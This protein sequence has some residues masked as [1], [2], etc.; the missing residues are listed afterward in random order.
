MLDT[1]GARLGAAALLVNAVTTILVFVRLRR[2]PDVFEDPFPD[3]ET[4]ARKA[5]FRG[6]VLV[7]LLWAL[8]V[9]FDADLATVGLGGGAFEPIDAGVG[10]VLGLLVVLGSVVSG[11]VVDRL[12]WDADSTSWA[13]LW[14]DSPREWAVYLPV[15]WV[16]PTVDATLYIGFV[17][18]GL[19]SG[20]TPAA[21]G[22][23]AATAL[24]SA[25]GSAWEGRGV[26]VRNLVVQLLLAFAFVV[27]RSLPVLAVALAV[28]AVAH[29]LQD[30]AAARYGTAA[31]AD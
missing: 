2:T 13:T 25:G 29:G 17:V 12:G 23:A 31:G 16:T 27:T 6:L 20:A 22:V 15:A 5:G 28:N 14:P 10:V 26:V 24:L 4:T 8:L 18:G 1:P 30:N 3:F 21:F 11:A 19:T 7:P 9:L